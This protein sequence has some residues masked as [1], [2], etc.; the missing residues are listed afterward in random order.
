L[1]IQLREDLFFVVKLVHQKLS[2]DY[3]EVTPTTGLLVISACILQPFWM[4][5]S[6]KKWVKR[7]DIQHENKTSYTIHYEE[8][9]LNYEENEYCAKH[10]CLPSTILASVVSNNL[11]FSILA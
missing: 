10:R 8:V 1:K 6:F 2:K 3:T 9:F 4:L 7:M 11:F 5:Q